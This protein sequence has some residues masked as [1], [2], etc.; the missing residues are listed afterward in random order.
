[1]I[2]TLMREQFQ[3]GDDPASFVIRR[4]RAAVGVARRRGLWSVVWKTRVKNWCD[5]LGRALNK[6]SWAAKTLVFHGKEWLQ[7]RR[8]MFAVGSNSSLSAGRTDTRAHRGIVHRRWHDGV[9]SASAS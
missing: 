6:D 3:A 4:N 8:R 2:R 5:H 9:D 7:E 1:M